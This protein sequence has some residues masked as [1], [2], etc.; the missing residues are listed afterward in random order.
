M[1][2]LMSMILVCMCMLLFAAC[3]TGEIKATVEAFP[4]IQAVDFNG[5]P[6]SNEIFKDYDATIVNFWSNSCGSCI[7]EMPELEQYYQSF[8]KENINLITVAISAGESE[9]LKREAET[10][11]KEKGVTYTNIIPNRESSFYKDFIEQITGYPTTY[12]V[13]GK[14][15]IIGAPIIGVVK[16][17]EDTLMKRLE[18]IKGN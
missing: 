4:E 2:K 7:E 12:I 11:L 18:I 13:D 14:G 15:N 9:A 16:N 6:V 5:N 8:K 3:G 1:K 17:Q 10:I